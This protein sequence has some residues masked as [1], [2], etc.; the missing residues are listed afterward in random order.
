MPSHLTLHRVDGANPG[1]LVVMNESC[2]ADL[3]LS[4]KVNGGQ[5]VKLVLRMND[6]R[7]H[8]TISETDPDDPLGSVLRLRAD[9][10]AEFF[11][12]SASI[13]HE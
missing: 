8:F 3:R 7:R 13:A 2:L 1:V 10:Q 9:G 5:E 4:E 6:E 11:L 12:P